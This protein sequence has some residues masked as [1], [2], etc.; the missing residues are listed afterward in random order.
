VTENDVRAIRASDQAIP[1][2]ARQYAVSETVIYNVVHRKTWKNV[3]EEVM[4]L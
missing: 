4:P 2:L 3:L 1:S